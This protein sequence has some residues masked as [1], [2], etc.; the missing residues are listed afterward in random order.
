MSRFAAPAPRRPAQETPEQKLRGFHDLA[1]DALDRATK[2]DALAQAA[3]ATTAPTTGPSSQPHHHHPPQQQNNNQHRQQQ[4]LQR[5]AALYRMGLDACREGLALPTPPSASGLSAGAD[6]VAAWRRDLERWRAAVEERLR[7]IEGGGAG[8]AGAKAEGNGVSSSGVVSRAAAAVAAAV[9][10]AVS[11]GGSSAAVPRPAAPTAAGR[12]PSPSRPAPSAVAPRRTTSTAAAAPPAYRSPSPPPT[13]P[14]AAPAAAATKANKPSSSSDSS[15][16]ERLRRLVLDEALETRPAVT[17]AD[18]AGLALAKQALREAV[19]LPALRPDL[20]RGLR[21]PARGV[22]LYGPPGNGKTMLCRALAAECNAEFFSISAASLTSKWLGES[23]KLMRALFAAAR[24]KAPSV[25]FFDELDAL[26]SARGSGT[27]HEAS[28]RLKTEFLVNV[29]GLASATAGAAKAAAGGGGRGG[30]EDERRVVVVGATN[31]PADLDDAVR[32]RL[33]KRIYVPLPDAEGR[34]AILKHLLA[35]GGGSPSV[36]GGG[37]GGGGSSF[38]GGSSRSSSS[39]GA[40]RLSSSD[41]QRVVAATDGYSASDLT[42][43]VKEAAMAPLRELSSSVLVRV[44]PEEVRALRLADFSAALRTVRPSV[45]PAQLA[46]YEAFTRD[47]G[48]V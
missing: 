2:L 18:V 9:K 7:E 33:T 1:R 45:A 12:A 6:S 42:A 36:S 5:A 34:A 3:S 14:A 25:I 27:E 19:V 29:D 10:G 37:G 16:A 30:G 4:L 23:E 28:R 48:A 20:F 38:F 46:A 24:E 26:L 44:R 8:A 17:F 32:R 47:F 13:R 39:S 43:L 15:E 11:G 22:L 31:R 40:A 21:S 41:L 35:G